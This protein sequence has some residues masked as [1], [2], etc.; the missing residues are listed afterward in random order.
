MTDC[1]QWSVLRWVLLLRC[2]VG[3]NVVTLVTQSSKITPLH[4]NSW[5]VIMAKVQ[6]FVSDKIGEPF[7]LPDDFQKEKE[8]ESKKYWEWFL[9]REKLLFDDLFEG[10]AVPGV[11]SDLSGRQRSS[12]ER[13]RML[14]LRSRQ[15]WRNWSPTA[16]S[17]LFSL[18]VSRRWRCWT[19]PY[20][21]VS[22]Q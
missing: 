12:W 1:G 19:P 11:S 7:E 13:R 18:L 22:I 20:W 3:G 17:S 14:I 4:S 5:L 8:K 9:F 21:P 10:L 6:P 2:Y 15:L 16:S